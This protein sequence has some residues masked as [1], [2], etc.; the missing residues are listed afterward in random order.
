MAE[1]DREV[2]ETHET[3]ISIADVPGAIVPVGTWP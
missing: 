1:V 3:R 2:V